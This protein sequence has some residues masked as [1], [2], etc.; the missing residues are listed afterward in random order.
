MTLGTGADAA[1][2]FGAIGLTLLIVGLEMAAS[3]ALFAETGEA[4]VLGV[5]LA[6]PIAS[7]PF[8]APLLGVLLQGRAPVTL[9][10]LPTVRPVQGGAVVELVGAF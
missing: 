1:V 10:V 2:G 5:G 8:V 9:A 7:I 3:I 4:L 6:V